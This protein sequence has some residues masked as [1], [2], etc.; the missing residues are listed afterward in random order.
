MNLVSDFNLKMRRRRPSPWRPALVMVWLLL[1]ACRGLAI[2]QSADAGY[3]TAQLGALTPH[4]EAY[5]Q[6]EPITVLPVSAAQVGVIAGLKVLP[7]MHVRTGEKLARLQGP[8]IT[9]LLVQ[10]RANV[11]STQKQLTAARKSLTIGREQ[12][13]AHLSTR[14]AVHQAESLVAQAQAAFDNARSRL[15]AVQQMATLS[16][17]ASAMVLTVNATDGELVS[18]GQPILTL[19]IENR[20]W[21]R[22]SYYGAD[23]SEI[24]VGMTGRFSPSDGG[25]SV[26][27]KV[28]AVFGSLGVGAAESI[29]LVPMSPKARWV[30]GESGDVT[31]DSRQRQLVAVPTRALILDQGKWWVMVHTAQG[32]RPQAVVPG[33]ARGWQTFLERGLQPGAEVV[34]E[35]AYLLFHRAISQNYENPD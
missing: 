20:L 8:E 23:L 5:G 4:L 25:E 19:Q 33:P 34:V 29:A 30:N 11:R 31:L 7:G 16:A 1:G 13:A 14:Q 2:G 3:V 21:L 35:N 26:P 27:V 24:R 22:A 6:V 15:Q 9:S 32:D 17:P 28:R 12:L 18:A 10:G